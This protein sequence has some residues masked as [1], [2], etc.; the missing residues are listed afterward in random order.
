MLIEHI[1]EHATEHP[2]KT[3]VVAC[4]GSLTFE[5]LCTEIAKT[6]L[7][8][9]QL[10]DKE[11]IGLLF[12]NSARFLIMILAAA[13]AGKVVALISKD[14]KAKELLRHIRLLGLQRV[15]MEREIWKK[16][17]DL[18]H[19][20]S[21]SYYSHG[22]IIELSCPRR[23]PPWH[24]CCH[25]E[26]FMIKITSG[27]ESLGKYSARSLQ[28]LVDEIEDTADTIDLSN[29][30]T[31]L[32][33]PPIS[34]SFG[35]IAGSLLPLYF[36]KTL[37]LE[38]VFFPDH[39][40]NLVNRFNINV[41]F[42]VPFMYHLLVKRLKRANVQFPTLHFCFTAGGPI[43]REIYEGIK[44]QTD[45]ALINDYGSIETGL[46]CLNCDMEHHFGSVGKPAKGVSIAIRDDAG[47]ILTTGQMGEI[48]VES[49]RISDHYVSPVEQN[50]LQYQNSYFKMRD[51]G[52]LDQEGYVFVLGRLDE[53]YNMAGKKAH[54]KE[55]LYWL[56][57]IDGI[58]E[59][60]LTSCQDPVRGD[61]ITAHIVVEDTDVTEHSLLQR[62]RVL[63]PEHMVPKRIHIIETIPKS[64][65]GKV[66]K[67]YLMNGSVS[68]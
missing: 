37:I 7:M 62:C 20:G 28:S 57:Q 6:E 48:C 11:P 54:A 18:K 8:L 4:D 31:F 36:G 5:K 34:H 52:Y 46:L 33:L 15:F 58:Q 51:Y 30:D 17:S 47:N 55:I 59:A 53:F 16:F 64:A 35:L 63:M 61:I 12:N 26:D 41:M 27:S 25:P 43:D 14:T 10:E 2:E 23:Q 68:Y 44:Q 40:I 45:A 29:E 56:Y 67:K 42:A 22:N 60:V 50:T 38:D 32:C 21:V 9:N 39:V 19:E 3:A 13:K 1:F 65:T 66:L 49:D 24:V